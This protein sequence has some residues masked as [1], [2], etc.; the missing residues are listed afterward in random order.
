MAVDVVTEFGANT[1]KFDS[2]V[3]KSSK[4]AQKNLENIGKGARVAGGRIG[5][6]SEKF[7]NLATGGK[8]GLIAAGLGLI[9][10][11]SQKISEFSEKMFEKA[12]QDVERM[13]KDFKAMQSVRSQKLNDQD[14]ALELLR[15]AAG[16]NNL[17][18][19]EQVELNRAI[20]TL[21]S[22]GVIGSGVSIKD[23]RLQG[24]NAT[25]DA[26][27]ENR[28]VAAR[29][30]EIDIEMRLLQAQINKYEEEYERLMAWRWDRVK[31]HIFMGY[32]YFVRDPE[33]AEEYQQKKQ[34]AL[35]QMAALSA[36]RA[37]L[38]DRSEF[39]GVRSDA[40]FAD[41]EAE[42]KK[43]LDAE[44]RKKLLKELTEK[45]SGISF[46]PGGS[47]Q[48]FTNSLTSRGGW[49]GGGK[50]WDTNRF[51]QQILQYNAQQ[52]ST[53]QN[54]EKQIEELQRI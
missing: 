1:K 51:Q 39:A 49:A 45:R 46:L 17:S 37:K 14:A 19:T 24:F 33:K 36:E 32:N 8:L 7:N 47:S 10:S 13:T 27:A 41:I 34:D 40:R 43:R 25:A 23:G 35:N 22:A 30:K 2:A 18:K 20:G 44:A 9:L 52:Q 21:K 15:S 53:L 31:D 3:E 29:R 42:E 16:K 48:M 12:V 11:I 54:I 50:V 4:K 6:L 38:V 5:E 26:S 28:L